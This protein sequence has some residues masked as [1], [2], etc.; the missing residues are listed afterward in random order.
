MPMAVD[1]RFACLATTP[2]AKASG[3]KTGVNPHRVSEFSG[4]RHR[5]GFGQWVHRIRTSSEAVE[6]ILRGRI[7]RREM[8]K[9]AGT[10]RE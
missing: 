9:R 4:W 2:K 5:R 8:S 7:R 1:D 3:L 6:G 10:G